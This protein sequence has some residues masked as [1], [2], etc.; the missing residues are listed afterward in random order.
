MSLVW[1]PDL[2]LGNTQIDDQHKR[3]FQIL[4]KLVGAVAENKGHEEVGGVLTSAAVF[5]AAHFRMEED[6]MAQFDYP[7]LAAHRMA[8]EAVRIQVERLVDQFHGGGLDPLELVNFMES[9]LQD[10]VQHEDR[11]LA[12]FLNALDQ[13]AG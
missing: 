1:S 9:W 5:V 8:H 11:P 3:I 4:A 2:L 10:H 6:L 13:A 7:E 12:E